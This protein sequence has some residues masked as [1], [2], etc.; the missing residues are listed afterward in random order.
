MKKATISMNEALLILMSALLQS[1]YQENTD[2]IE[3]EDN[4]ERDHRECRD[5]SQA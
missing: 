4:E 2:T 3:G 5:K 1:E